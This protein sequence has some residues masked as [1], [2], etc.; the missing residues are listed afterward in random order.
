MMDA[1]KGCKLVE[2]LMDNPTVINSKSKCKGD[3]SSESDGYHSDNS[4]EL[5]SSEQV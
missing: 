2:S 5:Q 4:N 1:M 3:N